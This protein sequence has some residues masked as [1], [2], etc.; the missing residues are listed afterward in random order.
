MLIVLLIAEVSWAGLG[1]SPYHIDVDL[2]FGATVGRTVVVRNLEDKPRL[3]QTS[4]YGVRSTPTGNL[5][6][7]DPE[8]RDS[9]GEIYEY[10]A[11]G[12]LIEIEPRE[13][14]VPAKSSAVFTV[15]IDAPNARAS[16]AFAGRAGILLFKSVSAGE[17]NQAVT[18]FRDAFQIVTLVLI[19]FEGHQQPQAELEKTE[20]LPQ[21]PGILRFSAT[22][23]NTGNVHLQPSGWVMVRNVDTG[24]LIVNLDMSSGTTLPS[25]STSH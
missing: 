12:A 8:G 19:R 13:T 25:C 14:I 4:V 1:V 6:W 9:D 2:P 11:I 18:L 23:K 5:I 17:E 10:G 24:Q 16:G 7:L 22:L 3:I 20:V 21:V 15:R